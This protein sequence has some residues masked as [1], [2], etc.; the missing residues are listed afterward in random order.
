[1]IIPAT[2]KFCD[3]GLGLRLAVVIGIFVNAF[4]AA[5]Q[6]P[7]AQSIRAIDRGSEYYNST[8][9]ADAATEKVLEKL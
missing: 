1:V 2:I 3:R 8:A 9:A 4:P 6:I 7:T 5:A